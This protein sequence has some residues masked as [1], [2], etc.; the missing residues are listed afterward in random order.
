MS[1]PEKNSY[2][3]GMAYVAACRSTCD[4]RHVGCVIADMDGHILTTGYNGSPPGHPHCD[5]HGHKLLEDGC[6][7]T[8]HAEANAVGHAARLGVS[9][10][11]SVAYV[12]THPCKDCV[13]LLSAAGVTKFYYSEAYR[14][15]IDKFARD[16]GTM[17]GEQISSEFI[18]KMIA[19]TK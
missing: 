13:K 12:T 4:R 6:V 1:R 16:L 9:L 2:L 10:L 17:R 3:M 7:R 15:L 14:P 5:T 19:V 18:G 8:I 11:G